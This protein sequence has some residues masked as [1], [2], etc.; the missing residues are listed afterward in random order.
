[1]STARLEFFRATRRHGDAGGERAHPHHP[2]GI[3]DDLVE[4]RGL[5]HR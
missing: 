5:G 4:F 1:M 3:G 2:V